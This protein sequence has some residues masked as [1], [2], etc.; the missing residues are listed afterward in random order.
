MK[1]SSLVAG[2]LLIQIADLVTEMKCVKHPYD[3]GI[4]AQKGI[5]F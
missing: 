1:R 3:Q 5:D 2:R 4:W